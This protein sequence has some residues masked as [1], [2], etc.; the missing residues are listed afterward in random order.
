MSEHKNISTLVTVKIFEIEINSTALKKNVIVEKDD[1]NVDTNDKT[2]AANLFES[3]IERERRQ[4]KDE[5]FSIASL[6]SKKQQ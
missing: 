2:A 1:A 6:L 4:L 3:R 5:Y